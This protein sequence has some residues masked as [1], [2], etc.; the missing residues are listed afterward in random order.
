MSLPSVFRKCVI[1]ARTI[2]L[3]EGE[4]KQRPRLEN[5]VLC[6]NGTK[7]LFFVAQWNECCPKTHVLAFGISSQILTPLRRSNA[8]S[9]ANR[10]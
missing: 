5:N 1:V 9:F 7:P 4:Q 8:A 2:E 10:T 3:S 6:Q